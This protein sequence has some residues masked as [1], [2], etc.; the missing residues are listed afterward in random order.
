MAAT[1]FS[2]DPKIVKV[3][4]KLQGDMHAGSRS[5]VLRRAI[6]LLKL[7]K[8]AEKEGA[9]LVIKTKDGKEQRIVIS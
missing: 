1:S 9:E 4:D 5:E 8:D 7:S 2:F 6:T 3:I